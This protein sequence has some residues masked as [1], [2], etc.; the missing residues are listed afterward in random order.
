MSMETLH[1]N[2]VEYRLISRQR[3]G[4]AVYRGP[5]ILRI[6]PPE[7]IRRHITIHHMME[8][9]GYPVPHLLS[10]GEHDGLLYFREDCLEGQRLNDAFADSIAAHGTI[11]ETL[12]DAFLG[13]SLRWLAAEANARR[14][15]D[16]L[17]LFRE[18]IHLDMLQ[19]ELPEHASAIERRW[20]EAEERLQSL[21]V[22][23]SHGDFNAANTFPGGVIDIEDAIMAPLGYDAATALVT[24]DWFP[25]GDEYEFQARYRFSDAQRTRFI[26]ACDQ[27]LE[28]A[29]FVRLSTVFSDFEFARAVWM[30]VR[31]H[32]WPRL[33]QYR[34]SRFI[35]S[36]L[37]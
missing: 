17:P 8:S 5:D 22:V 21:P 36:F 33:Q 29:G 23:L 4:G 11:E 32:Q 30:C 19:A 18:G 20:R 24:V 3:G 2:G 10:E 25:S 7:L 13:I 9:S 16:Y 27:R 6:G 1:L 28:E 26:S 14:G 15:A 31:M 34:Y 12:F 35:E 37:A